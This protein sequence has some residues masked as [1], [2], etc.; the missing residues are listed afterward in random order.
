MRHV[1]VISLH[2][3]QFYFNAGVTLYLYCILFSETPQIIKLVYLCRRRDNAIMSGVY[4]PSN[5]III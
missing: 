4:I 3:T 2:Y 5:N 1:S